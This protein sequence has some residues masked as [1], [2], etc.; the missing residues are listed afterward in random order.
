M[1]FYHQIKYKNCEPGCKNGPIVGEPTL[2]KA[3]R[4]GN[5]KIEDDDHIIEVY[6]DN[7]VIQEG[8]CIACSLSNLKREPADHKEYQ[9]LKQTMYENP[10]LYVTPQ[11]PQYTEEEKAKYLEKC[12]IVYEYECLARGQEPDKNPDFLQ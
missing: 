2:C 3:V 10:G 7:Q 1:C 5:M 9:K 11:I 6:G 4:A 8:S 12:R